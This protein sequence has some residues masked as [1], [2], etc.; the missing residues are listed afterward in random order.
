MI[1]LEKAVADLVKSAKF[2]NKR[3]DTR[4]DRQRLVG[5]YRTILT[6]LDSTELIPQVE[7][8]IMAAPK[9]L[10]DLELE[11]LDDGTFAEVVRIMKDCPLSEEDAVGYF[12]LFQ[13]YM[14][15]F[16][17]HGKHLNKAFYK[18]AMQEILQYLRGVEDRCGQ[19]V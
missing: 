13:K 3:S 1:Q 2:L 17:Q 15:P 4:Q 16:M 14:V 12:K 5:V 8:A 7:S 19:E 9:G 18:K 6:A 10:I 11:S